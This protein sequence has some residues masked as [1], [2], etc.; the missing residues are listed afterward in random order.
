MENPQRI[1]AR[2]GQN[3]F[4]KPQPFFHS[5]QP[6]AVLPFMM[7]P[8]P[9]KGQTFPTISSP[10][11]SGSTAFFSTFGAAFLR[12]VFAAAGF[13]AVSFPAEP[14]FAAAFTSSSE[15]TVT[16]RL[17]VSLIT[18]YTISVTICFS[19]LINVAAS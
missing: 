10:T 5:E 11:I 13:A 7:V 1:Y 8:L 2:R 19:S 6:Y 15:V 4:L 14:F 18:L 9:H 3:G 12:G 16:R 17:L